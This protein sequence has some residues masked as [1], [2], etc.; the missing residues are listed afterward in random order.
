MRD[1]RGDLET[2]RTALREACAKRAPAE[3]YFW[4]GESLGAKAHARSHGAYQRYL[5]LEPSGSTPTARVA[6]SAALIVRLQRPLLRTRS[7]RSERVLM[8]LEL[9]QEQAM[10]QQTARDFARAK[11]SRVAKDLDR[12]GE[13][14]TDIVAQMGELG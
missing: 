6:R 3:A 14:P 11:S 1:K 7:I 4:L 9:T 10:L 2:A 5:E 13:W 8:D 12:N